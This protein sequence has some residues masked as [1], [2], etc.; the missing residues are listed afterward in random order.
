[1]VSRGGRLTSAGACLH[2]WREMNITDEELRKQLLFILNQSIDIDWIWNGE[3]EIRQELF[4]TG[5]AMVSLTKL[6]KKYCNVREE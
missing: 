6:F 5:Y 2:K 4:D 1:M 3:D